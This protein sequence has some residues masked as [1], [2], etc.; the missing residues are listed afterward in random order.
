MTDV[1]RESLVDGMDDE[2]EAI[3]DDLDED[4]NK[5]KRFTKR[6]YD[7]Y[8]EKPG[9]LSDSEDEDENA[10]DGGSRKPTH[11]K[12]RNQ[13]NYRFDLA[14]SGIESG[15]A[16]PQDASSVPEDDVD[17]GADAK[18]AE[19]PEPEAVSKAQGVPSAAEEQS[20][21]GNG[22]VDEPIDMAIDA[23]EPAPTSVP[24]S[25]PG[26]PKSRDEDTTMADAGTT[27]PEAK[28]D[29]PPATGDTTDAKPAEGTLVPESTVAESTPQATAPPER[30][31]GEERKDTET[32]EQ[33]ESQPVT[34]EPKEKIPEAPGAEPPA[35]EATQ[36]TSKS[37]EPSTEPQAEASKHEEKAQQ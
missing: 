30:H 9:E 29:R 14:D 2:A 5:D 3:L 32:A 35:V 37:Q 11:L 25:R 15:M 33:A 28:Q 26:S 24:V 23:R 20:K 8:I 18:M 19:A 22:P 21:A 16:T 27:A 6:Q 17:T 31:E 34:A 7:Q 10:V 36:E 4:E 12:R 13:A 1:P